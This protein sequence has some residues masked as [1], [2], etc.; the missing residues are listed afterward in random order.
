[1]KVELS[2]EGSI[3][4]IC[5]W[6][7]HFYSGDRQR[8]EEQDDDYADDQ[9]GENFVDS[10]KDFSDLKALQAKEKLINDQDY[11]SDYEDDESELKE[12]P[13]DKS[14]EI[15]K[16]SQNH[17]DA[18]NYHPYDSEAEEDDYEEPGNNIKFIE[19]NRENQLKPESD[20]DNLSELQEQSEEEKKDSP[21]YEKKFTGKIIGLDSDQSNSEKLIPNPDA[22]E[23]YDSDENYLEEQH[24]QSLSPQN[25]EKYS[26]EDGDYS[27]EKQDI[28]PDNPEFSNQ[29]GRLFFNCLR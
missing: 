17:R 12:T 29:I 27:E 4:V 13:K 2:L 21:E 16:V 15:T 25:E 28:M 22:G 6:N 3:L 9:N 18:Q 24:K 11:D 20:Y 26:D 19:D 14:N 23:Y 5:K 10:F 8:D 1:M 7:A